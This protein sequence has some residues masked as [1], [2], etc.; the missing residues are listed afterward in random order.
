V[1]AAVLAAGASG[2]ALPAAAAPVAYA[3]D[4]AAGSGASLSVR[5]PDTLRIVGLG[6]SLTAGYEY[7]MEKLAAP[8]PY[9]YVD[10]VYEQ[11]LFHGRAEA[12]NYGI[13]GLKT[14]D[15]HK[16]LIAVEAGT[17]ISAAELESAAVDPRAAAIVGGSARIR[18]DL[19][20]ADLV[21]ITIGANDFSALVKGGAANR[22]GELDR[23]LAA[24]DAELDASLRLLYELQPS[25]RVVVADQYSP[26]PFNKLLPV[27]KE[28]YDFYWE[29][30]DRLTA[31]LEEIAARFKREGRD[32]R[33]A[34]AAAGFKGREMS[35]TSVLASKGQDFHPNRDGYQVI[36]QAFAEAVW[37][38]FRTVAPRP[39]GVPISVVV[40][41]KE[42][43]GPYKPVSKAGRTY[44]VLADVARAT[45]ARLLWDNKTKTATLMLNG[46]TVALTVDAKSMVV[47]GRRVPVESPAFLLQAGKEKKTYVP[48]S[49]IAAG[50]GLQ[51][52]YRPQLKTAF[53]NS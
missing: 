26:V 31:K 30:A 20:Q 33:V 46:H 12:A 48:L 38:E 34:Y 11:A 19:Q 53:I 8:V 2:E 25:V 1:L 49:A 13:L 3:S 9:G 45:G 18:T 40:D 17:P 39:E 29:A 6:D 23:L 22:A 24:Y 50:L 36:G 37:G 21:V 7:G 41:G 51:V 44:L 42:V 32:A 27:T 28:D 4:A 15:L 43:L 16:L 52:V 5:Q 35:L 10:R 14:G 47:D